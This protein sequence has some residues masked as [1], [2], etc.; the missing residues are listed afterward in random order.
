M[1]D[2]TSETTI[3]NASSPASAGSLADTTTRDKTIYWIATGIVCSVMVF[4]AVNFNLSN[5]L[6]PMKGGF[7]HLGYPNYF[8]IELTAAKILGVLAMLIPGVPRQVKGFA[9]SGFAITLISASIAHF[10]VGDSLMFIVDPLLF[11][12]ALAVSYFYWN[13]NVEAV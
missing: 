1:S 3:S 13:R 10:S 8:K 5:P 9:Y 12:T 6:G 2:F 4:S 7:A 11:L